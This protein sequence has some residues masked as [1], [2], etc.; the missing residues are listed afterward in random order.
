[1]GKRNFMIEMSNTN[2]QEANNAAGVIDIV[3][4]NRF[5]KTM[6]HY[7]DVVDDMYYMVFKTSYNR[8]RD[9]INILENKYPGQCTY[10]RV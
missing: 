8:M 4:R 5:G 2:R 7:S 9:I 6:P 10:R 1:M 3:I